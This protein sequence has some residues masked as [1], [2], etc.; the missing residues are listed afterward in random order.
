MNLSYSEFINR[1][2]LDIKACTR[3]DIG[4]FILDDKVKTVFGYFPFA[5]YLL[6]YRSQKFETMINSESVIGYSRDNFLLGGLPAS[7]RNLHPEDFQ[8]FSEKLFPEVLNYYMN[9]PKSERHDYRVTYNYRY[10]RK[11]GIYIHLQQH[12]VFTDF[13]EMHLPAR[14]FSIITDIS[15]CKKD[16]SLNLTITK[17]MNGKEEVVLSKKFSIEKHNLLTSREKE[18]LSLTMKGYTGKEIA[19][20]LFISLNTVRNHKQHMMEKTNTM[21]IA[22]LIDYAL[23][24]EPV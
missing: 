4:N 15:A 20:K 2:S 16:T 11:D 7:L 3:T 6:D 12:S 8:V 5:Y 21:N 24:Y 10:R 23:T 18:I 19:G 14:S 1:Q 9:L 13:N 17:L 22:S